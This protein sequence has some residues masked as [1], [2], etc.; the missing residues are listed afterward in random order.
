MRVAGQTEVGWV[1][2]HA[3]RI[4]YGQLATGTNYNYNAVSGAAGG[5]GDI[6]ITS[7]S[8]YLWRVTKD[9]SQFIYGPCTP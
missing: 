7:G 1:D 9:C 3:K 8:K 2:G 5:N 6:T 4:G